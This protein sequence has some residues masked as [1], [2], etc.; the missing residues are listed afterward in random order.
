MTSIRTVPC[1]ASP[2]ERELPGR[3]AEAFGLAASPLV[4]ER[5]LDLADARIVL[6]PTPQSGTIRRPPRGERADRCQSLA[7][8]ASGR[9]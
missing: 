6:L 1:R 7:P 5:T 9:G 2:D 3:S 8:A 4:A